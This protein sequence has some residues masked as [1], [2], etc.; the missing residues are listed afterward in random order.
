MTDR[1]L[2]RKVWEYGHFHNPA[3]PECHGVT[4]ADIDTIPIDDPRVQTAIASF[5]AFMLPETPNAAVDVK[6]LADEPRCSCPDFPPPGAA[7]GSGSWPQPC[8]KGGVKVHIDKSRMPASLA[9]R[10]PEIQKTVFAAYAEIGLKLVEHPDKATANIH[11]QWQVL[12][13]STIGLAEFNSEHCGD[14]VFCKL[15]PGYTGYVASLFA[16]ELGHNCNLQHRSQGG[17]MHPSIRP[18]PSPFTWK[19]DP[20]HGDL[21]RYFGGEPIDPPSPEPNPTP[22]NPAVLGTLTLTASL[23]AGG[24]LIVKDVGVVPQPKPF[25]V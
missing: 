14:Q 4:A 10:W 17:I 6:A 23:P 13:G 12:A 7:V 8:Q 2:I 21:I 1:E 9:A 19:G 24:Y 11:V 5:K 15:D 22:T 25:P 16:H 20:S 18:D 3:H